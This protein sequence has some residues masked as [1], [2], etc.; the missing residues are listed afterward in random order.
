MSGEQVCK[1]ASG[2]GRVDALVFRGDG[3]VAATAEGK[4]IVLWNAGSGEVCGELAGHTDWVSAVAWSGDG[5]RLASLGGDRSIRVWDV[6]GGTL[7]RIYPEAAHWGDSVVWHP[8]GRSLVTSFMRS[9][10]IWSVDESKCIGMLPGH[11]QEIKTLDWSA[12]GQTLASGARD[13]AVCLWDVEAG[14]LKKGIRKQPVTNASSA[15]RAE[16]VTEVEFRRLMREWGAAQDKDM[17]EQAHYNM[18]TGNLREG[19]WLWRRTDG[20]VAGR[21]EKYPYRGEFQFVYSVV[22]RGDKD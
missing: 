11:D 14:H 6:D 19:V 16:S 9:I 2:A 15:G 22:V 3:Q 10:R 8:D 18:V 5:R 12:D 17:S 21:Q 20:T 7:E 4:R 1:R 13:G